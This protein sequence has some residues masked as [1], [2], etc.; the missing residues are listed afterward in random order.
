MTPV[1]VLLNYNSRDGPCNFSMSSL[2]GLGFH[3]ASSNGIT[4]N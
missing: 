4:K 2:E 3:L 1:D